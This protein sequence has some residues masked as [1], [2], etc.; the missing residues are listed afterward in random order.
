MI[1]ST[2]PTVIE[3]RLARG[4]CI[5]GAPLTEGTRERSHLEQLL[6]EAHQI[7]ESKELLRTLNDG[8]K[9]TLRDLESEDS[10]H[11]RLRQSQANNQRCIQRQHDLEE[12]VGDL[13]ARIRGIKETNLEELERVVGQEE[14]E[15]KRLHSEIGRTEQAIRQLDNQIKE[16]DRERS[17]LE[18]KNAKLQSGVANETAAKDILAVI[19]ST[20]GVLQGETLDEVSEKMNEIFMAMIVA[21]EEAG[22][23]V[24]KA[25]LTRDHDIVVMGPGG[26]TIDPDVDLNGASRRALTLAFIL[27]LVKVSGVKAPNIIDTPLGMMGVEVRQAV[28]RY[29]AVHSSQLVMFLTGSEITGVEDLLD[30]FAG[31]FYTF[32]NAAH[33]PTKLLNDPGTSRMETL[34]CSCNHR[35][36]CDLCRRRVGVVPEPVEV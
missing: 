19:R 10:W 35:Q 27:A 29:A 2:L 14:K 17:V 26:L 8:V 3:D 16:T 4:E 12:K 1:P 23:V 6:E 15:V 21:D 30:E 32:S 24:K 31:K 7:D 13:R 5:C 33:Y 28:L 25:V 36:T 34:V 11:E 20:I 18:R 9:R 22:S